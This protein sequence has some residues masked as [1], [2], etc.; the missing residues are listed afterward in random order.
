LK[1]F[2]ITHCFFFAITGNFPKICK[3]IVQKGADPEIESAYNLAK[4]K[5]GELFAALEPLLED[6][7]LNVGECSLCEE[8]TSLYPLECGHNIFCYTC[9]SN[10]SK[11]CVKIG[12]PPKCPDQT[13]SAPIPNNSLQQLLPP[14][15]YQTYL[16]QLL[17]A[18]LSSTEN[19]FWC[20]HCPGG[21]IA[22]DGYDCM[23]TCPYCRISWCPKCNLRHSGDI[24]CE[25]AKKYQSIEDEQNNNWKNTNSKQCPGCKVFIEKT[26][27]CTHMT[28]SNCKYAFCWA[29][30]GPYVGRYSF[31][32]V[33]H[34]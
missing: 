6:Q 29:C 27:G 12:K 28:C 13:C 3:I 19:F 1:K 18:T 2:K 4:K 24:P 10:W 30:M 31:N 33:C 14:N 22:I 26:E 34:C 32:D 5:G 7:L 20:P 11:E 15:Q 8:T 16:S 17:M 25:E 9:C 23:F 21:F